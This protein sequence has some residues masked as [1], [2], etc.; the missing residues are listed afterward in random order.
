MTSRKVTAMEW[1][2]NENKL[3]CIMI[4]MP[5]DSKCNPLI[6]TTQK[7]HINA[8]NYAKICL[9]VHQ[10]SP[11]KYEEFDTWLFSNHNFPKQLSKVREY[12]EKIVGEKILNETINS[13]SLLDQLATNIEV[14][15]LNSKNGKTTIMPQTIIKNRVMFGP[16][17][18][19]QALEKILIQTLDLK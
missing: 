13:Q 9:A 5:L 10:I 12:A 7:D 2:V 3:S 4:P 15:N 1:I 11:R 19:T 18:S 8:C 16:P 6:K 17:P 14:Y